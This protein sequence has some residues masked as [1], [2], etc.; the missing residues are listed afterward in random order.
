MPYCIVPI[1]RIFCSHYPCFLLSLVLL[2][3]S[4]VLFCFLF[5]AS[6]EFSICLGLLQNPPCVGCHKSSPAVL[7]YIIQVTIFGVLSIYLFSC[8]CIG[9]CLTIVYL[10]TSS[11]HKCAAQNQHVQVCAVVVNCCYMCIFKCLKT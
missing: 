9:S 7:A 6:S 5:M 8:H 1:E 3:S 2:D 4:F 11:V 10:W